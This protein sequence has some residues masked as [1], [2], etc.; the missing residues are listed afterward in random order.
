[1][2]KKIVFY[3][4]KGGVGKSP[5]TLEMAIRFARMG[6]RVL[7]LDLSVQFQATTSLGCE[8]S[9]SFYDLVSARV[10]DITK[11]IQRSRLKGVDI[12][13]SG[14]A[15][16]TAQN[17]A[18]ARH[19]QITWLDQVLAQVA[20]QYDI[21]LVDTDQGGLFVD[22]AIATADMIVS[23]VRCQQ[24]HI[25]AL[26]NTP[27]YVNSVRGGVGKPYPMTVVVPI[28]GG[29][30]KQAERMFAMLREQIEC[31]QPNP[32]NPSNLDN[33]ALFTID[34]DP[35]PV[36]VEIDNAKGL[37]KPLSL[38]EYRP[39]HPVSVAYNLLAEELAGV[40]WGGQQ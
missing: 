15:G 26:A 37:E 7:I 3:S 38:L 4:G 12:V 6:K 34:G 33:W 36:T 18:F 20:D 32:S 11:C 2:A 29:S 9:N 17:I 22:M 21:V 8:P 27:N 40:L 31:H 24:S 28:C 5:I 30:S 25:E 39:K 14:D 19:F 10:P 35:V 16:N 1:M 13:T 23:P